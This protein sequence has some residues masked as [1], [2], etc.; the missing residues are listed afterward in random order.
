MM[1]ADNPACCPIIKN[2]WKTRLVYVTC[3]LKTHAFFP[4]AV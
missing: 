1:V 4:N 3:V 2:P